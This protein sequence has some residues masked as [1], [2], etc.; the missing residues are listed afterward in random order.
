LSHHNKHSLV[1]KVHF[2]IPA[3]DQTEPAHGGVRRSAQICKLL[4]DA[5]VKISQ[6]LTSADYVGYSLKNPFL[7]LVALR[8]VRRIGI[9][10]FTLKGFA[11]AFLQGAWLS[12]ELNRSSGGS[13]SIEVAPGRNLILAAL[14]AASGRRFKAYPHNV[15][16]LVPGQRQPYFRGSSKEF[17]IERMVYLGAEKILTISSFDAAVIS[18]L[19][20]TNV[21]VLPYEPVGEYLNDLRKI[22]EARVG[23][24][25]SGVLILGTVGNKPTE[26]GISQL[27]LEIEQQSQRIRFT[28]AGYGTEHFTDTAP[29]NV[30]VVGSVSQERLFELMSTCEGLLINQPQTSGMLT[31]LVEANIAGVPVY[32]ISDYLQASDPS[33]RGVTRIKS[34]SEL[35]INTANE[36]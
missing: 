11:V 12:A 35:P 4:E 31:R 32:M 27:L 6:P 22:Y 25:K 21:K 26:A 36:S 10:N 15:E 7:F 28:L 5:G 30:H 18:S 23:K 1:K 14:L 2:H 9:F 19:G 3:F 13:V 16:F 34:L 20:A 33:L 24:P 17:Q 8:W 29:R